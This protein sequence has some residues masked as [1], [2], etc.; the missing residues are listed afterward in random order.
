MEGKPTPYVEALSSMK[1]GCTDIT[2]STQ[3]LFFLTTIRDILT[4]SHS[5]DAPLVPTRLAKAV[6]P[7]I[8]VIL[9]SPS[10]PQSA[11]NIPGR[12]K[13][14]K[15][16]SRG[17]EGD[18]VFKLSREVIC[19]TIDDGKVLLT[20]LEGMSQAWFRISFVLMPFPSDTT[21]LA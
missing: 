2:P 12:G 13:K 17:Y 3:R 8:S 19:P 5:P 21:S 4:H 16:R 14:A 1:K 10:G 20:A 7:S 11:E 9:S 15:K 18:E 6:L